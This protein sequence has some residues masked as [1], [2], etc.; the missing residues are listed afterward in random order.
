MS[1]YLVDRKQ[2]FIVKHV[3][4]HIAKCAM[5]CGIDILLGKIIHLQY[6]ISPNDNISIVYSYSVSLAHT[7]MYYE[8]HVLEV[9]MVGI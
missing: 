7:L 8:V 6:V 4:L 2:N 3:K 5:T 9:C 1:V